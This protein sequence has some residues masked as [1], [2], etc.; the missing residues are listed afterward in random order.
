MT[1][2]S[3]QLKLNCY[4]L[5]SNIRDVE[6]ALRP[7]YRPGG[8]APLSR[9][10]GSSSAPPGAI[11]YLGET[12]DRSPKWAQQLDRTFPGVATRVV[13][14]SN[15]MVI[16][17]P[18]DARWF[19]ICFGYGAGTLESDSIEGNFGL[20]VAARILPAHD[21]LE[22]RSRRID[23]TA[24]TQYVQVPAGAHLRELGV[25]LDGEFVRKLTGRL[26]SDLD[27]HPSGVVIAG[28]SISFK[29]SSELRQV[30]LVLGQ[31]LR[32]LNESGP[33]EAFQFID[34]LQP[35]KSSGTITKQLETRLAADL[36]DLQDGAVD[37]T[38]MVGHVLEFTPPD[39]VG[40][41]FDVVRLS[42]GSRATEISDLSLGALRSALTDIGVRSG[43][44]FLK[45]VRVIALGP[46]GQELSQL[47]PL[48]HW[49]VYEIGDATSRFIL[50]LGRWFSLQESYTHK[51]NAD[52][53]RI[54][55]LT[56]ELLL[57]D[58]KFGESEGD[59]NM[60][61]ARTSASILLMDS[62]LMATEDGD[63]IEVCD[64]LHLDGH[65]I[66]V[67]K[68]RGS[69]TM[70]HLFAQGAVSAELLNSDQVTQSAFV[71]DV[72]ARSRSH[73]RVASDAPKSVTYAI[74]VNNGRKIPLELPTFSK[75]NLRD[76]ARKLHRMG[77]NPSIA[78]IT[79][80]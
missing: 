64:L 79:I 62:R 12:S 18:V 1:S 65:L 27:E 4:L 52:L 77:V 56:E 26:P 29:A 74:A 80:T 61:V 25:E 17:V 19:A 54:V 38:N 55:D 30:Q 44:G 24:R 60:R 63:R 47:L 32:S 11:A 3:K 53:A 34:S 37:N 6:M 40:A 39:E 2:D 68:F 46:D 78:T 67:K 57:P 48:K 59:Y 72:G 36:L 15:R 35:L 75:V 20:R 22:L 28:D 66:H 13:N 50:T 42:S 21:V 31:M 70:S 10:T 23:A 14:R 41:D 45:S 16:F 5:R 33:Q 8:K 7:K 69:Q 9:L 73:L 43:T 71:S 49:L 76:F 51:L 58:M